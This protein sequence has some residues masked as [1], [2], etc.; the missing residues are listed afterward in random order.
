MPNMEV[1]TVGAAELGADGLVYATRAAAVGCVVA[2][3]ALG[4]AWELWLAPTG[5]RSLSIKVL[6][7]V[8]PLPG[9]L[10]MRLYT[11]RWLSLLVWLYFAEG[12]VRATSE[13]GAVQTLAWAEAALALL[14]FGACAMHVWWRLRRARRVA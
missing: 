14:L 3:I 7:L 1:G 11:Y 6:P 12:M 2:L 9:L 4:L 8:L 10:K 13:S 5:S